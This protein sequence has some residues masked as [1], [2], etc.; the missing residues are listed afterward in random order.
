MLAATGGSTRA[1]YCYLARSGGLYDGVIHGDS[2]KV[3]GCRNRLHVRTQR[4]CTIDRAQARTRI[5]QNVLGRCDV[6]CVRSREARCSTEHYVSRRARRERDIHT[7]PVAVAA[8]VGKRH[9]D[10]RGRICDIDRLERRETGC[11]NCQDAGAVAR[12]V[13]IV[14]AEPDMVTA[15]TKRER[16]SA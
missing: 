1:S 9:N 15:A 11:G 10:T 2:R 8:T 12:D 16:L 7:L 5:E 3:P 6:D 14:R 4:Q 13:G